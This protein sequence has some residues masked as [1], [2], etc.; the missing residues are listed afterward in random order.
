MTTFIVFQRALIV[1]LGF[2]S[3]L[4]TNFPYDFAEGSY[5]LC[6]TSPS[7][8]QEVAGP[9]LPLAVCA[10]HSGLPARRDLQP[11]S[12]LPS[13]TGDRLPG[14][15]A[16]IS[17]ESR[18]KE[19]NPLQGNKQVFIPL[20]HHLPPLSLCSSSLAADPVSTTSCAY[21]SL[22]IPA[23]PGPCLLLSI[24]LE[25][26]HRLHLPQYPSFMK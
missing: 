19:W 4:C 25:T 5:P 21:R 3:L 22:C 8:Q 15:S 23:P 7:V 20:P 6:L 10:S 1:Q 16:P 17:T 11:F 18:G 26:Q 9:R 24:P 2:N 13:C 14:S 12:T